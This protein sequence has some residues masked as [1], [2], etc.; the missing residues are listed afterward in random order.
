LA[1]SL[2]NNIPGLR[3]LVTLAIVANLLLAT[4]VSAQISSNP[5]PMWEGYQKTETDLADDQKFIADV[6]KLTDGNRQQASQA[7]VQIGWKRMGQDANHAIRAFNQAWLL[8][9][10][11][12][13]VFWGF[14][15][16]AHIR[17]DEIKTITRWFNR[18]RQLM[19]LKGVP[20]NARLEADHGRVLAER[21]QYSEALTLFEK[22][23]ALDPDYVPAHIGMINVAKALG[24]MELE[25]KHQTIHDELV[26]G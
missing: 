25:E 17:N 18:T 19:T 2:K 20:E 3:G 6:L 1:D 10:E 16:A 5:N 15:V 13:N 12:P 21:K 9:P 26:K 4:P 24:N 8:E 11:N 23:I 7:L 22:S 14:A